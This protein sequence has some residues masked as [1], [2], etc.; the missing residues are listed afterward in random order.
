MEELIKTTKVYTKCG[1]EKEL[2]EFGKDKRSKDDLRGTCKKSRSLENKKEKQKEYYDANRDKIL[3]KNKNRYHENIEENRLKSKNKSADNRAEINRKSRELYNKNKGAISIKRKNISDN[4][5]LLRRAKARK[6][7]SENKDKIR[8]YGIKDRETHNVRI[9]SY[10]IKNKD[11]INTQKNKI[12][13]EKL[14]SDPVYKLA[15]NIRTRIYL[16]LKIR[17]ITKRNKTFE[18]VGCTPE[19]L[20]IYLEN[21]FTIG[22]N[23]DNQGKWHIDHI[24][25]L[26]SAVTEDDVLKL[27]HYTNLQPL[28]A[29]DNLRKH[30]KIIKM[31]DLQQARKEINEIIKKKQEDLC[32]TFIEDTH[33][34]FM[35]DINGV[36]RNDWPSVST[37]HEEFYEPFDA[38]STKSFQK[39]EGDVE[40]EKALLAE[41]ALT[42]V[43]A[44]NKGSRVHFELEKEAVRQYGNYK[45]VRKP[46]F[47]VTEQ[48][49]IDG[50]N[51]I[52]AGKKFLDLMHERGAILL[53]TECILGSFQ[54]GYVG[55]P[56]KI[57][58]IPN[59]QKTQI[60]ILTTDWKSNK[61]KN[62]EVQWYTKK[63]YPPYDEFHATSLGHYYV[64]LS[65]Y[66]RLLLDMLKGSK[67]ENIKVLGGIVVLLTD[68]GDFEEFRV[69]AKILNGILASDLSPYINNI[70]KHK[71]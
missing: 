49:I 40:A 31:T 22:M 64:Q 51:M 61:K 4:K 44:S 23:W 37:V 14:L 57:W 46:I 21:K 45:E 69:P 42:G 38:T 29:I 7:A 9:K 20:K 12:R 68:E 65:L 15:K 41:W 50:D 48:Q 39:L 1:E 27:C 55:T 10:N 60:G 16:Y 54:L 8:L 32:L 35:N 24:I 11:K 56:D 19:E 70:K 28:W 5:L 43:V 52:L 26:S 66:S 71:N 3:E 2:S 36:I 63:L 25:P 17:N 34:Y 53:D 62:F 18:I 30:N 59:K 67:Y 33:T 13:N 6:W 47:E 58:L